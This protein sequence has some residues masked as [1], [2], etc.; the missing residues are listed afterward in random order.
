MTQLWNDL[1]E[2]VTSAFGILREDDEF[3][4]VTLACE[5]GKQFDSKQGDTSKLKPILP[6]YLEKGQAFSLVCFKKKTFSRKI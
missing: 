5:D 4:D 3:S 1:K 6:K 2:N